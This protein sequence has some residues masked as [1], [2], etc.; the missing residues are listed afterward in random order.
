MKNRVGCKYKIQLED[1]FDGK[2]YCTC[3][4][5]L[6]EDLP[7]C[8]DNCQIF[9]DYK[10]LV[11]KLKEVEDFRDAIKKL[12]KENQNLFN[13]NLKLEGEI[14]VVKRE[15][16]KLNESLDYADK[17]L[18]E[19][20]KT[21]C[22]DCES[23]VIADNKKIYKSY[24]KSL[25]ESHRYRK[26]LEEIEKELKEDVYCESQECGCD[27]FKECLNCVKTQI[28][29]IINKA[30]GGVKDSTINEVNNASK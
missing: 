8:D 28:L 29:D 9:E 30:K 20:I 22:S 19:V 15:C 10:E 18:Q 26:A 4:C 13:R 16:K 24:A 2:P 12:N 11:Q 17:Q 25:D 23:V 7:I 1:K 5:E 27:D 14:A 3:F 6:C 21:K